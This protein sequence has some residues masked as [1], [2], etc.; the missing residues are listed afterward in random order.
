MF[1]YKK[2]CFFCFKTTK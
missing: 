1:L 2:T